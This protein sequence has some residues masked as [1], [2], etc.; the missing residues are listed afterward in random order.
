MKKRNRNL[1]VA[2]T[3]TIAAMGIWIAYQQL[4]LNVQTNQASIDYGLD[5]KSQT[6]YYNYSENIINVWCR[7]G[8]GMDGSFSLSVSFINAT[9]SQQQYKV[10]DRVVKY[11]FLLH[12][13]S[14]LGDSNNQ[15]VAFTIDDNVSGFSISVSLE[16]DQNSLKVTPYQYQFIQCN[17]N[18]Q[19]NSFEIVD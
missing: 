7:N 9:V 16:K 17:W 11:P 8:G 14:A 12:K 3:I 10:N 5:T 2:I 18:S 15:N 4:Q 6:R 1:S 13:S 19:S